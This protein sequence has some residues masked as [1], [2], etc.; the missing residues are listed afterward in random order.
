MF[1]GDYPDFSDQLYFV[2]KE[3]YE[4]HCRKTALGDSAPKVLS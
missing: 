1:A 2:G 3:P 4:K